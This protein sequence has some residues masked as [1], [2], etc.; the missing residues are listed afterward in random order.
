MNSVQLLVGSILSM[1]AVSVLLVAV[2]ATSRIGR[3]VLDASRQAAA[4]PY[5]GLLL[6]VAAGDDDSG[7]AAAQVSAVSD[8]AW[9]PV[10]DAAV[11]LLSK[12]RGEAA[13]HLVRLLDERRELDKARA[14]LRSR[15][16]VRRARNAHLL[17]LAGRDQDVDVLIP[18]LADR[19]SEVRMVAARSLGLVGA[20]RAAGALI[21]ALAPVRRRPGIP[22]AVA[23]EA[24]LGLGVRALPAIREALTT[25]EIDQRVVAAMVAADGAYSGV[26]PQLR[27][28]LVNDQE[29]DVRMFAARA[30]GAAGSRDDM[31]VLATHTADG[32]PAELRRT[33][34]A[35]LGELGDPSAGTVLV[36]LLADPDIRLAQLAAEAL[37]RLGHT[38]LD[39]LSV[40]ALAGG[41]SGRIAAVALSMA[42]LRDGAELY[43]GV[44]S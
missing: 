38:G 36:Q 2:V 25:G 13:V 3:L 28:R 22:T 31:A 42:R 17:G 39:L 1:A 4:A 14:A 19:S 20:D 44:G 15:S 5:R 6:T 26:L 34:V 43:S 35:A 33:A 8:R 29:L 18:L 32:Q 30:V 10:R 16:A 21:G 12:V 40:V 41:R 23:A 37:A 9:S 7:A 24:L 11:A 27:D